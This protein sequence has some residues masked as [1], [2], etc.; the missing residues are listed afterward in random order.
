MEIGSSTIK[1]DASIDSQEDAI[2]FAQEMPKYP[3]GE[4]QMMFDINYNSPYPEMEK[5]NNIQG[6]VFVQFV[7][8]KDGYVSN[9]RTI[10]GVKGGPNLSTV[11]ESAVKRLKRFSPATQNGRPVRLVMS[12][13]VHFHLK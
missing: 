5:E 13:P 2:P 11:A 7:V 9:V 10:Q 12:I 1:N 4:E 3:G 6:T 8:E